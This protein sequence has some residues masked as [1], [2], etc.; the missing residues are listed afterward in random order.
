MSSYFDTV[1]VK[2]SPPTPLPA[3]EGSCFVLTHFGGNPVSPKWI[4]EDVRDIWVV[5]YAALPRR[6]AIRFR[7]KRTLDDPEFAQTIETAVG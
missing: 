6:E 5:K 1:S 4:I 3:G 7:R 2:P